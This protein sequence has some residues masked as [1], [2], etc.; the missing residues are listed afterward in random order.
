MATLRDERD[1]R[2]DAGETIASIDAD[3]AARGID[4]RAIG[5]PRAAGATRAATGGPSDAERAPGA[6]RRRPPEILETIDRGDGR[7]ATRYRW[8]VA[9]GTHADGSPMAPSEGEDWAHG[10]VTP[11]SRAI[12][13]DRWTGLLRRRDATKL[14]RRL[15]EVLAES[16]P[17]PHAPRCLRRERRHRWRGRRPGGNSGGMRGDTDRHRG[18]L[19]TPTRAQDGTA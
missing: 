11:L 9:G 12:L 8:H 16:R 1:R 6:V 4:P 19:D 15:D 14:Q 13:E 7:L 10:P 2:W 18:R 3:F 17:W 5:S